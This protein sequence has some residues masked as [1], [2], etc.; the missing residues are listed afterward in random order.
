MLDVRR[1]IVTK[2]KEVLPNT[3][4]ELNIESPTLPLITY[5]VIDDSVNAYGDTI[6]YSDIIFQVKVWDTSVSDIAQYTTEIDTKLKSLGLTRTYYTDLL[7]GDVIIGVMQYSG[8]IYE[9]F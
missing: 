5:S 9:E 4:Y 2:L 6:G 8:L 3:R 7:S 1:N